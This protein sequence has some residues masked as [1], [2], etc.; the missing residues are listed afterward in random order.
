[1]LRTRIIGG[2]TL[3]VVLGVLSMLYIYRSLDQVTGYLARLDHVDVPFSIAAIEMEKNA[4][5]YALGVLRYSVFPNPEVRKEAGNDRDD[6]HH[7]LKSYMRLSTSERKREFGRKADTEHERLIAAG[8]AMMD[9]R[10]QLDAEF[11]RVDDVLEELDVLVDERMERVTPG[12][13]PARSQHLAA[14]ANIEAEAA[15]VGFWLAVFERR[16]EQKSQQRVQ[17]KLAELKGAIESYQAMPLTQPERQL[18]DAAMGLYTKVAN[19]V[20][21]LIVGEAKQIK[22]TGSFVALHA[23]LDDMFDDQIQALAEQGLTQPQIDADAAL[24]RVQTA[25]RYLIPLYFVLAATLGILLIIAIIRPLRR[26]ASGTEVIGAGNLDYRV[27]EQGSDE[28]SLLAR[29]FNQMVARLQDSTVSRGLLEVSERKLQQTVLDLRQEISDRQQAERE[30]E[31][32]Q[33]ELR[34]NEAMAAMGSLV[35]G[36]AHEVRNPLFGISSTLDAMEANTE[37]NAALTRY[38]D[39]L[40]REANRMNKL[41]VDLLE[42]GKPAATAMET[43]AFAVI[44]AEAACACRAAAQAAGVT[45]VNHAEADAPVRMRRDRLLQVFVNLLDNAVQHAPTAS[46]VT[47]STGV[48]E[49]DGQSWI[50]CCV[51][52]TGSGFAEAD[53]PHVFDPFFTRRRRGT[54]LGLAIVQRIVEEHCGTVVP[55][56]HPEGGGMVRVRLPVAVAMLPVPPDASDGQDSHRSAGSS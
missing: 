56:N 43:E 2:I 26:L 11:A 55:S 21:N 27:A 46:Q 49:Q 48:V 18:A 52:D 7:Y 38:Q 44:P 14:V 17:E 6:F 9:Q 4:E 34:R 41:M 39:V 20:A 25:M 29:Q 32:L 15:E 54:G 30:R 5:E 33:G 3:I 23:K 37:T 45:L 19:G 10:D 28:F 35:A 36:V 1:M 31:Q 40:R 53:L 16:P 47:I 51:R 12:R 24:N 22:I 50:E 42:Y 8:E 13:E